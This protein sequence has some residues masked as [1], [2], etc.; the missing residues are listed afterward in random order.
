MFDSLKY[1]ANFFACINL[2]NGCRHGSAYLYPMTSMPLACRPNS[3]GSCPD[4]YECEFS[5]SNQ[6]HQCCSGGLSR[7]GVGVS[8]INEYEKPKP[9]PRLP[10]VPTRPVYPQQIMPNPQ[11]PSQQTCNTRESNENFDCPYQL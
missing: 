8:S 2:G 5:T 10:V 9:Q 3:A 4:G 11:M 6:Q 7:S 1:Y